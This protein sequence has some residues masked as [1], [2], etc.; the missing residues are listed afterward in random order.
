MS[1]L[2][3]VKY[4]AGGVHSTVGPVHLKHRGPSLAPIID[5]SDCTEI[6]AVGYTVYY[7]VLHAAGR[8]HRTASVCLSVLLL[9]RVV[10]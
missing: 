7:L 9:T 3:N 2:F 10:L 8:M 1:T 6:A 4:W 5:A